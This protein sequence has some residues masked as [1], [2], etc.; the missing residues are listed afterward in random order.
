MPVFTCTHNIP[1]WCSFSDIQPTLGLETLSICWVINCILLLFE[2]AF[3]GLL[4]ELMISFS[5]LLVYWP[6]ESLNPWLVFSPMIWRALW[7]KTI[8]PL[9]LIYVANIFPWLSSAL[10]LCSWENVNRI[11]GYTLSE[12]KWFLLLSLSIKQEKWK[13]TRFNAGLEGHFSYRTLQTVKEVTLGHAQALFGLIGLGV[14]RDRREW[15]QGFQWGSLSLPP[16]WPV[17]ISC[18]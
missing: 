4:V 17:F 6:Y 8:N 14:V 16:P 12:T 3:L 5:F 13:E 15:G 18:T 1:P 7:N 11:S 9:F 10:W 2:F